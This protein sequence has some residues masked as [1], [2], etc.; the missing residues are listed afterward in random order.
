MINVGSEVTRA[1]AAG[2]VLELAELL[3]TPVSQG[4]SPFGDVPF[5]HPLFAGFAGMGFPR[6]VRRSDVFL[7]LGAL[8][9]DESIITQPVKDT[10]RVINAR[11]DYDTI[12]NRYPTDIAIAAGMDETAQAL[13]D[14]I[15]SMA[16]DEQLQAL[17]EPRMAKAEADYAKAKTVCASARRKP[18]TARRLLQNACATRWTACSKRM[19]S[20]WSRPAGVIRRTG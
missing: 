17:R 3:G 19:Q 20:W 6:G 10:T 4:F 18:G 8:M 11:L 9:P 12:A 2:T 7:N 13:L 14:A 15:H 5:S 16:T 1:G